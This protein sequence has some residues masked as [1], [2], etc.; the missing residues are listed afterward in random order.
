[1]SVRSAALAFQRFS[2]F[3]ASSRPPVEHPHQIDLALIERYL[4][5]IA[6]LPLSES[7][8]AL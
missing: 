6:P 7:T 4:A 1:M 2:A 5:W 8:K 3:L